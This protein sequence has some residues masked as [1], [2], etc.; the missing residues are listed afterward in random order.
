MADKYHSTTLIVISV[1][2]SSKEE[3]F[4]D[5]DQQL[6]E[7]SNSVPKSDISP[8]FLDVTAITVN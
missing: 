7:L 1:M 3:Q 2:A 5:Q 6:G 8:I 4:K